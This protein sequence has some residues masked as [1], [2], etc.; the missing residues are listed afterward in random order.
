MR[1][2]KDKQMKWEKLLWDAGRAALVAA[3][4][5]AIP[6][7]ANKQ[8]WYA[9]AAVAVGTAILNWLRHRKD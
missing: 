5:V 8:E 9:V 4:G 3:V 1:G 7:F 6:Y 2:G